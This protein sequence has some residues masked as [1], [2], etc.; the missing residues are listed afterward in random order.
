[1]EFSAQQISLLLGGKITG[2]VDRKVSDIG[3]IESA[4]E[5]QLTFLCDAKYLA[6]LPT[7]QASVVLMTA[8]IPFEG[9][10]SATIIR[11]ENARAAMGQLLTLE[12]TAPDGSRD[13]LWRTVFVIKRIDKRRKIRDSI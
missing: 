7:T 2:D 3:S 4:K 12:R 1:M 10:T 9:E 5:G 11:V 6:Y 13:S 8:S